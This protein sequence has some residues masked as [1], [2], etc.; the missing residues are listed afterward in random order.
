MTRVQ[1][2]KERDVDAEGSVLKP[3]QKS[4]VEKKIKALNKKLQ[5]IQE[6]LDKQK[7]GYELDSQQL[8]KVES[9]GK[10]LEELDD[11][12]SGRRD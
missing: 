9:L 3:T 4:T 8:V 7:N 2:K 5:A 10:T 1:E 12:V 6:L 11:F